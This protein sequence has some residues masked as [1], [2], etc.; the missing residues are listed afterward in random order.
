ME[1]IYISKSLIKVLDFLASFLVMAAI[2]IL[3]INCIDWFESN[4]DIPIFR[5]I[6]CFTIGYFV[7]PLVYETVYK[8]I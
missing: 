4:Y 1:K 5:F 6:A 7:G 8:K 3:V 2:I